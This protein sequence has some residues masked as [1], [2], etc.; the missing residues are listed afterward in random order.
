MSL[1]AFMQV[2]LNIYVKLFSVVLISMNI[3]LQGKVMC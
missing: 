2:V 1:L 3:S